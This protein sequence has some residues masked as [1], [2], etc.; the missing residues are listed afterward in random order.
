M[1][2]EPGHRNDNNTED[3]SNELKR[4]RKPDSP[5]YTAKGT[6]DRDGGHAE[7]F[8][9]GRDNYSNNSQRRNL[10]TN[11]NRNKHRR[12]FDHGKKPSADTTEN[13]KNDDN[14]NPIPDSQDSGPPTTNHRSAV[15]N[16][17]TKSYERNVNNA[18]A[19]TRG[20]EGE[21]VTQ[22]KPIDQHGVRDHN[23][24]NY[25]NNKNNQY[26]HQNRRNYNEYYDR[27]GGG[28][29]HGRR[30]RD[31]RQYYDEY[32]N[33]P[34]NR[35]YQQS[36]SRYSSSQD[37]SS[38]KYASNETLHRQNRPYRGSQS[39][40]ARNR[41]RNIDNRYERNYRRDGEGDYGKNNQYNNGRRNSQQ[42]SNNNSQQ[43]S[44]NNRYN[45]R[46][47][48][49]PVASSPVDIPS[50]DP[51]DLTSP[52]S[53][54][55]EDNV[56]VT[57]LSDQLN[58]TH[59]TDQSEQRDQ[60]QESNPEGEDNTEG[61]NS[62]NL[63]FHW[64]R[65][66]W[67]E[68][69]DEDVWVTS[70]KSNEPQELPR[71]DPSPPSSTSKPSPPP[72]PYDDKDWSAVRNKP[73]SDDTSS[74][75]SWSSSRQNNNSNQ[76]WSR[77]QN[78]R[79]GHSD[80]K[81]GW[82]GGSS[83][84]HHQGQNSYGSSQDYND[85]YGEP[86]RKQYNS[87]S[88]A[89]PGARGGRNQ[90]QGSYWELP[91]RF[92]KKFEQE[93][94]QQ[95]PPPPRT[96]NPQPPSSYSS[97]QPPPSL[98]DSPYHSLGTY[99]DSQWSGESVE[100]R[101]HTRQDNSKFNSLPPPGRSRHEGAPRGDYNRDRRFSTAY[102][103]D[104]GDYAARPNETDQPQSLPVSSVKQDRPN[105]TS[106]FSWS[107]EAEH[108]DKLEKLK[109][110]LQV[111]ESRGEGRG[112]GG[113]QRRGRDVLGGGGYDK[114][115]RSS[116][117]SRRRRRKSGSSQGSRRR[118][119]S[120]DTVD[121]NIS[122][123][124]TGTTR[125]RKNS[126][127]SAA[128]EKNWRDRP[129]SYEY[130]RSSEVSNWR[131]RSGQPSATDNWNRASHQTRAALGSFSTAADKDSTS[132]RRPHPPQISEEPAPRPQGPCPTTTSSVPRPQP[133]CPSN[134][135][136]RPQ[137]PCPSNSV[138]RP[139][140]PTTSPAPPLI[141]GLIKLPTQSFSEPS[142]DYPTF[143]ATHTYPS[144]QTPV[145]FRTPQLYNPHNPSHPI[146]VHSSH[147]RP[148]LNANPA[149]NTS[150]IEY[151]TINGQVLSPP[152]D[153]NGM[154]V[155]AVPKHWY[156]RDKLMKAPKQLLTCVQAN[157]EIFTIL[158][159]HSWTCDFARLARIRQTIKDTLEWFVC[160]EIKFCQAENVESN[161]WKLAFYNVI[162][163]VKN[164]PSS[165]PEY[166]KLLNDIIEDAI[167]YF[168]KL[169]STL[170][171]CYKFKLE[172][173][174]NA[175]GCSLKNII[176]Y[177]LQSALKICIF[178]GDLSRY[179]VTFN[180]TNN[181]AV[182]S[183]W[184]MKANQLN[185]RNGRPFNQ[186]GLIAVSERRQLDAIYYYSR[187]LLTPN[188]LR[189]AHERL[190]TV[191]DENRKKYESSYSCLANNNN[192]LLDQKKKETREYRREIWIHPEDNKSTRRNQLINDSDTEVEA[193]ALEKL[194]TLTH[195][196]LMKQ[197]TC[198]F[199]MVHG[200]LFSKTGLDSLPQISKQMLREFK[201]LLKQ[202]GFNN[203]R[204]LQ[205]LSINMFAI[206]IA[207]LKENKIGAE[208]YKSLT[209]ELALIVSLEMFYC[210]V[211][212]CNCLFPENESRPDAP[213]TS[214]PLLTLLPSIKI[215]C[216]WFVC[217]T[218]IWNPPPS[219]SDYH[220]GPRDI[221]TELATFI[222]NLLT[223]QYDY[224]L[225]VPSESD[226]PVGT[227]GKWATLVR[228]PEDVM[229]FGYKPLISNVQDPLYT[230]ATNKMEL[231]Y[232]C[233][234]IKIILF[235]GTEFL[236]GIDPPVLKLHKTES[237][238][239]EYI[240]I[241][242]VI[243]KGESDE[244]DTGDEESKSL[245]FDDEEAPKSEE[246]YLPEGG[247]M[248]MSS[249]YQELMQKREILNKQ[250]EQ[251][252]MKKRILENHKKIRVQLEIKPHYLVP[253]T[254]CFID[255]LTELKML[256]NKKMAQTSTAVLKRNLFTILIPCI[257]FNELTNISKS[258][259]KSV[260]VVQN[261]QRALQ[262]IQNETTSVKYV[263]T[264]GTFLSK[265]T[266]SMEEDDLLLKNDDKILETCLSLARKKANKK[267]EKE[268]K[269]EDGLEI[270]FRDVVLLT[271]DR[272]LRLK[273]LARDIPVTNIN[274]FIKWC[275]VRGSS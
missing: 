41:P 90:F 160:N 49:D 183:S 129:Q 104:T 155:S 5:L 93:A 105:E 148:Q 159:T 130:S 114:H 186:L 78:H 231:V 267:P 174:L 25:K 215:W 23:R 191:F 266:F 205:L 274:N 181:F 106:K 36:D 107:E 275:N 63:A 146:P 97:S 51:V 255:Y 16:Q 58:S 24:N 224:D 117:R 133:P 45:N 4:N 261:A 119:V 167:V 221:W 96:S 204:L 151:L 1:A 74:V 193:E 91:P 147:I 171:E 6:T 67:T 158:N 31:D 176:G 230:H 113:Y 269:G 28:R 131:D 251:C 153:G 102:D 168:E 201:L 227:K 128:S 138:P 116:S 260:Q 75:H 61:S 188:Y 124:T 182:A 79:G 60:E 38:D 92:R 62:V 144:P 209:Q 165:D 46:N 125:S 177:A 108:E 20:E 87:N 22:T 142:K 52:T 12:D 2:D 196:E 21:T 203:R 68:S 109:S 32:N 220:I 85:R 98:G 34:Y 268:D 94:N 50:S 240:S 253:D 84:R 54:P 136:S 247:E 228:L 271:E 161:L 172:D 80:G 11:N 211:H 37:I 184:Y 44:N 185:P 48:Q 110:A 257:V 169:L 265:K 55:M 236:V 149:V 17:S 264:K 206:E 15:L 223:I 256:A 57:E 89:P 259:K 190:I 33:R 14:S 121:T 249:D 214:E 207:Q 19:P 26:P 43:Y 127:R 111:N 86:K 39:D 244:E 103:A 115:S 263:T 47:T 69:V 254:N 273:A 9:R 187:S 88:T 99:S 137:G 229:F 123:T 250:E 179:K 216:D 150:H 141:G 200:K 248:K 72:V 197:F 13:S 218:T 246:K 112:R 234:R 53:D 59:L 77:Q 241:V 83:F 225:L 42:Y 175:D 66:D 126:D 198:S 118:S 189:S 27:G 235:F 76:N 270:I 157:N 208:N 30:D 40:L 180:A 213:I 212:Q 202:N 95:Q 139:Q 10:F 199:L 162:E 243:S 239:D 194:A 237:G 82:G 262:Y 178:L 29:H 64:S 134:S 132:W 217:Q 3:T 120:R 222:N 70:S 140:A 252:E 145:P 65:L 56:G 8:R 71:L 154:I 101:G 163:A 242:E 166:K 238:L 195:V 170:G 245:E 272:N 156:A 73:Q 226:A 152:P 210:L 100:V 7:H 135:V 233:A 173:Y 164:Y 232:T 143:S 258:N 81:G 219:C 35:S 192:V 18:P 122:S